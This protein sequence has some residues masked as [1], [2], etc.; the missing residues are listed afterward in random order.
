MKKRVRQSVLVRS[1]QPAGRDRLTFIGVM[2]RVYQLGKSQ[3]SSNLGS[4][5]ISGKAMKRAIKA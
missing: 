2:V 3:D 5:M 1:L 4:G